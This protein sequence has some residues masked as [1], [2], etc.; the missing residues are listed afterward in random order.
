MMGQCCTLPQQPGKVPHCTMSPVQGTLW[1]V[2]QHSIYWCHHLPKWPCALT[3][4]SSSLL[5]HVCVRSAHSEDIPWYCYWA[6]HYTHSYSHDHPLPCQWCWGRY[7]RGALHWGQRSWLQWCYYWQDGWSSWAMWGGNPWQFDLPIQECEQHE[8]SK[9][10]VGSMWSGQ[11]QQW[12]LGYDIFL[13][14]LLLYVKAH[15]SLN[16]YQK[17][18]TRYST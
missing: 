2:I 16:F 10:G 6:P 17:K 5:W 1:G 12:P 3:V 15:K 13:V 9:E 14:N 4:Q 11:W 18:I 7:R 8:G